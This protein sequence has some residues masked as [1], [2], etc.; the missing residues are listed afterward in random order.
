MGNV[1]GDAFLKAFG[2]IVP[3]ILFSGLALAPIYM[4][5]SVISNEQQIE[6]NR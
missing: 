2:T 4:I 3:V 5:G 6:V 1:W